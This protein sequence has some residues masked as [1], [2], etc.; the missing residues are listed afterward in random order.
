[1][2]RTNIVLQINKDLV[3]GDLQLPSLPKVTLMVREAVANPNQD[4]SSLAKVVQ[5]DPAFCGYLVN[6]ANSPLYRGIGELHNVQQALSRLGMKTTQNL[7][8]TYAARSLFKPRNRALS[9][10]LTAIW[11]QSTLVAALAKVMAQHSQG[12]DPDEALLAGLLQDIDML[13]LLDK[14]ARDVALINDAAAVD[15]LL[16]QHSARVGAAVLRHWGMAVS[17]QNVAKHRENWLREHD[18]EADL[19]DLISLA[20]IHSYIGQPQMQVLPRIHQLP[21]FRKLE[22]GELGPS[23]SYRFIEQAGDSIR[24]TQLSLS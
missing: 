15:A 1:M 21:A 22:L 24:E 8:M 23:L 19:V 12:F 3:T 9:T 6:S 4:L 11:K 14:A 13:P 20:R 18:G 5:T 10:W 16:K 7:A 17:F 2:S